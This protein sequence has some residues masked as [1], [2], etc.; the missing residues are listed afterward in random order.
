MEFYEQRWKEIYSELNKKNKKFIVFFKGFP[1][2]FYNTLDTSA[3]F[4][5]KEDRYSNEYG[6]I[7]GKG[8]LEEKNNLMVKFLTATESGLWGYY[9]E[10]ITLCESL[11][12]I[13]DSFNG[14]IYIINNNL[15]EKNSFLDL[16]DNV[17]EQLWYYYNQEEHMIN[18]SLEA[19]VKLYSN[20]VKYNENDYVFS[21]INKH[22]EEGIEEIDFFSSNDI[23][24]SEIDSDY[25]PIF[26]NDYRFEL[27]KNEIQNGKSI[28]KVNIVMALVPVPRFGKTLTHR[29]S[30]TT[31][32]EYRKRQLQYKYGKLI[33]PTSF[34]YIQF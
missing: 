18:P 8:L 7:D 26:V 29:G 17:K 16:D 20:A 12:H 1:T 9:E 23:S 11:V 32:K 5:F 33:D 24:F 2:K 28:D 27:I 30:G 15:F 22:V 31:S 34:E 3:Y 25:N 6:Y 21:Y 19:E 10:F 4:G 14:D 13:K